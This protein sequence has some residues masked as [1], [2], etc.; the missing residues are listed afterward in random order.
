MY[1]KIY[2][3][4]KPLFLCDE[5]A[6]EISDYAKHDDSILMDEFSTAAINSILHEMRLEKVHAGIFCHHDL[7]KL[8]K[9]FW[10]KFQVIQAGG[11]VV[12]NREKEPLFIF[13]R[14]KW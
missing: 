3:D 14:G 6:G 8:K 1:I 12:L 4:N 5:I 2:F 7:V 13:R 11:G 9:S 10:K